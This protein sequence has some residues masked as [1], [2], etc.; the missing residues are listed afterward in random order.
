MTEEQPYINILDQK[1]EYRDERRS[2]FALSFYGKNPRVLSKLMRAKKLYGTPDE[3]QLAIEEGMRTEASVRALLKTIVQHGGISEPLIIQE[4]GEVLEG[5]S[6]LAALR[7]L[8]QKNP[9][10][11]YITAPCK[12][13]LFDENEIDAFLHQQHVDGK[14]QWSA[15]DKA[16]S[17]YHRVEIDEVPIEEYAKRTS[18]TEKEIS[19]QIE[20]ISLM[21]SEGVG[22]KTER[23]SYYHQMICSTKLKKSFE[24]NSELKKHLL[25]QLQEAE[26]PFAAK[27]LRDNVPKIADKPKLLTKWLKGKVDFEEAVQLSQVSQPKQ[28][29]KKA[30]NNLREVNRDDIDKLNNNDTGALETEFKKCMKEVKRIGNILERNSNE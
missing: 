19:K 22:D 7:I 5:N 24:V 13:V 12:V 17:A 20:I 26:I 11:K 15:Y 4:N 10:E 23:Y 3:K 29:I 30:I 14:V 6:R 8:Y 2:I 9:K 1:I 18:N 28:Q 25:T 21:Q 16:Y 27:D